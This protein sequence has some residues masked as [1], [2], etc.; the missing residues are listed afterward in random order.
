MTKLPILVVDD[1]PDTGNIMLKLLSAWGY[2]ADVARD[3]QSALQLA[4]S[5]QYGL[6]IIDYMMPGMNGVELQRQL[7]AR[8]PE[9]DTIFLTGYTTIDVVYP[10]VEAGVIRVLPKPV[11][12]QE[13]LPIIEDHLQARA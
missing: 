9:L 12:L 6:A 8:H 11:D 13:L 2:E 4:E 10:A 7:H 1:E 5:K 3:G